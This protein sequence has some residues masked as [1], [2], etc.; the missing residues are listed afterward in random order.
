MNVNNLTGF[1]P[2]QLAADQLRTSLQER[3]TAFTRQTQIQV[4]FDHDGD[5]L[6]FS[7]AH[8]NLTPFSLI[9]RKVILCP[10][11]VPKKKF[12]PALAPVQG[13][14][15]KPP[16]HFPNRRQFLRDGYSGS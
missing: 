4:R 9:L 1:I 15:R 14:A 8:K 16:E 7:C 2:Q 5:E 11:F 6:L 12:F 13:K 10:E 3:G